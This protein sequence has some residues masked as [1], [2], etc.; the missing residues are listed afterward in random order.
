MPLVASCSHS[1]H[2]SVDPP[3]EEIENQLISSTISVLMSLVMRGNSM[4]FYL[5]QPRQRYEVATPVHHKGMDKCFS[6]PFLFCFLLSLL[7]VSYNGKTKMDGYST[8]HIA[9]YTRTNTQHRMIYR[10]VHS[11][12]HTA[13]S[14]FQ[15]LKLVFCKDTYY[16]GNKIHHYVLRI[17]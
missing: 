1:Q 8:V 11:S 17:S 12:R 2:A 16:S 13:P 5:G 7:L 6:F 10:L 14:C 15:N 4:L 3:S 9:W